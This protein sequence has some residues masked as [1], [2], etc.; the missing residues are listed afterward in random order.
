M[1]HVGNNFSFA[2]IAPFVEEWSTMCAPNVKL[3]N[4]GNDAEQICPSNINITM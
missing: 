4:D 2:D 3:K 1:I